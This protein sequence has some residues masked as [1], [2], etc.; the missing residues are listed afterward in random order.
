MGVLACPQLCS[1][2]CRSALLTVP[3]HCP[4]HPSVSR[5]DVLYKPRHFFHHFLPWACFLGS[6]SVMIHPG[7]GAGSL[8]TLP[9]PRLVKDSNLIPIAHQRPACTCPLRRGW[10]L[11]PL[12][13]GARAVS[14]AAGHQALVS[15]SEHNSSEREGG[16][17]GGSLPLIDQ[18]RLPPFTPCLFITPPQMM[19]ASPVLFS[20]SLEIFSSL[21]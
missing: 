1:A 21:K 7:A 10:G 2:G 14:L 12:L 11:C 17:G 16:D 18:T 19:A 15:F 8:V 9:V 20:L 4:E 5:G 6:V 13:P 3:L